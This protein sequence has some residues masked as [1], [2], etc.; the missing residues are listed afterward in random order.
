MYSNITNYKQRQTD[1][2]FTVHIIHLSSIL[3][4]KKKPFPKYPK[5]ATGNFR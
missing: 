5:S 2:R 4:G 1:L 3:L